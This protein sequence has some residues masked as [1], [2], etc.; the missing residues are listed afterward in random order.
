MKIICRAAR[1]RTVSFAIVVVIPDGWLII[2]SL[3]I[4]SADRRLRILPLRFPICRRHNRATAVHIAG[5]VNGI[6]AAVHHVSQADNH[7]YVERRA[8]AYYPVR[9]VFKNVGILSVV[10]LRIGKEDDAEVGI[11]GRDRDLRLRIAEEKLW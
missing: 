4:Q 8:M 2:N 3:A 1:L 5:A 10:V 11:A 9:L 7:F 6:A